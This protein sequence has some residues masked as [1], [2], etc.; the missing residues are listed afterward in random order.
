MHS[1]RYHLPGI[2]HV[3]TDPADEE[4]AFVI[5]TLRGD[6]PADAKRRD[7]RILMPIDLDQNKANYQ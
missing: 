7:E 4:A 2:G 3:F 5:V 1:L 6:K